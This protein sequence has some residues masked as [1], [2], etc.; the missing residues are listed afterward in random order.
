M[1]KAGI[2]HILRLPA[3][4]ACLPAPRPQALVPPLFSFL[5]TTL[6]V[7]YTAFLREGL[8]LQVSAGQFG[9]PSLLVSYLCTN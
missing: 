8:G 1:N 2:A 4:V 5:F 6:L 9:C 3:P 7:D